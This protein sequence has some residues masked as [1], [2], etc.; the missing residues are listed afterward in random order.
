[1]EDKKI[2]PQESMAIISSMI[3][4]SKQRVAMPDLRISIMW[5]SLTIV[6]AAVVLALSLTAYAP[7]VNFIWFAIPVIGFPVMMLMA[8][9]NDNRKGV[10]TYVDKISDGIWRIVSS[11]AILVTVICIVFQAAGY[12]GAWL[13]MLFYAFIVVG[14]GA[15]IQGIVIEERSYVFGG[16]FSAIIGFAVMALSFCGVSLSVVWAIPLYIFCFLLMFIVPAF[17]ISRRYNRKSV[18]E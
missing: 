8:R 2:T 14:F 13:S 12:Y 7:W 17:I 15:A 10:K 16:M 1:M 4:A 11:I 9:K 18:S 6:T 3:Y 5:A